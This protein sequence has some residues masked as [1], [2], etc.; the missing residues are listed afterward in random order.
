MAHCSSWGILH[1]M[2]YYTDDMVIPES[3]AAKLA[4]LCL[5]VVDHQAMEAYHLVTDTHR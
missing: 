3:Y 1:L 5:M 4:I 2:C